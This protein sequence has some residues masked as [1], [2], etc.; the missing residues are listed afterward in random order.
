[1]ANYRIGCGDDEL[2]VRE[3]LNADELQP[4]AGWL[5]TFLGDDAILPL[6]EEHVQSVVEVY[7]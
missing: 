7:G 4:E 2:V 6:R 3:T 5:V 1:M